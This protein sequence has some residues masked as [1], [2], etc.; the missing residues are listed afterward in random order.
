[1]AN[2]S[3]SRSS[4]TDWK[5]IPLAQLVSIMKATSQNSSQRD[6]WAMDWIT[7]M[8]RSPGQSMELTLTPW[9]SLIT[10]PICLKFWLVH[11]SCCSTLC[12]LLTLSR[13]SQHSPFSVCVSPLWQQPSTTFWFIWVT[14][15]LRTWLKKLSLC[16]YSEMES[17][18][19]CKVIN[20]SQEILLILLRK[21]C[22]TVS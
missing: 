18:S 20:L 13:T 22:V 16:G 11:S 12:V 1:M 9:R 15:K 4:N 8:W 19:K 17:L 5:E 14:K 6:T 21:L 10:L 7:K 3:T 2:F